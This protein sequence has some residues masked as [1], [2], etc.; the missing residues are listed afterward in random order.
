MPRAPVYLDYNATAP[1]R[2]EAQEA[3]LRALK[4]PS[5]PSS[6]HAAGRAARDIVETARTQVAALVGVPAG[7]VTFVSGGTEAN[8]LAI[9]S[10]RACGFT[11]IVVGATEHDAVMETAKASGLPV[12]AWPVDAR[13]V[14]Q[15]SWLEAELNGP[16]RA[17]VCLMLANN[18][19]GVIQPVAEAS[20]L[21]RAA[22]GWLHVDAVQ[23]AGKIAIDFSALGADT[24]AL[25]AHKLGG[26]QGVGA[27][28]AGTRATLH[29]RQHGGGQERGRRAGTENVAGIAAFGAAAEAAV[30]DLAKLSEQTQWRDAL[31]E[32]VKAEGA[33]VLGEGADRLP[34]TLC[35]AGEGF[36][37]EIQVM[38]LDLAGVMASA[39]SACSSGKVKASRVVEAMGHSNLAPFALRVSGGWASTED[40]WIKCGDAWIAAWKRIGARRREVA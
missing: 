17:L 34:Q 18:E 40:D 10:A 36:G 23:A 32:R 15:L 39:G 12:E 28:V 19:T 8:A 7:S 3:M 20:V 11:R 21:V 6:V 27:L 25:S 16:G 13:G 37:S 29:R 14:A 35:F 4:V 9:E 1:I 26:P 5:N 24:M 2:P 30:R 31:A 22:D 33:V 38:N